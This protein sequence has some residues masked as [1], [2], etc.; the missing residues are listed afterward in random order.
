MQVAT[1]LATSTQPV[2]DGT[3]RCWALLMGFRLYWRGGGRSMLAQ[4]RVGGMPHGPGRIFLAQSACDGTQ[5]VDIRI[6]TGY[7]HISSHCLLS[8]K[9]IIPQCAGKKCASKSNQKSAIVPLTYSTP[10]ISMPPS[11]RDGSHSDFSL[12]RK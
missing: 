5:C 7:H 3:K 6:H 11:T 4:P 8:F 9:W 1:R 12:D 2:R 10:W